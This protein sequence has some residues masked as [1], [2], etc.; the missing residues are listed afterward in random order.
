MKIAG[1]I[2]LWV[3][4]AAIL[5]ALPFWVSAYYVSLAVTLLMAITLATSWNV[6]SG[7]TGYVSLGQ[8][9]F[10]GIGAYS[11]AVSHVLFELPPAL[12]FMISALI[13][14]LSATVIGYVLLSTRM[15]VAYFAVIMLGLNEITKTIVANT[16]AIGSSY[17]IS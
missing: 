7:M 1:L 9:I 4:L 11:F 8:G 12:C 10:F 13:P 16:K 5:I 3:T 17:G 2:G 15:R 6:F 14:A